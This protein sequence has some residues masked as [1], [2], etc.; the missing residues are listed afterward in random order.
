MAELAP[1]NAASLVP[2]G[3]FAGK[4][5]MPLTRPVIVVGS[6]KNSRVLFK[7]DTVST[8]HSLLIHTDAGW[9]V[10]DLSSRTHTILNGKP[11]RESPL[12]NG[13]TITIGA[14]V[15]HF[16]TVGG[17]AK[18]IP[19]PPAA[20]EITGAEIPVPIDT[21]TML[22]GRRPGCEV[23]LLEESASLIHAVIFESDGVHYLR[24][25]Y[26]RN[27]TYLNDVKT[28]QSP[29]KFGDVIRIGETVLKYV[30][31]RSVDTFDDDISVSPTAALT[32]T[33]EEAASE[34]GSLPAVAD[35][36][37]I[38]DRAVAAA[39]T[40]PVELPDDADAPVVPLGRP[41]RPTSLAE[42]LIAGRTSPL[43]AKAPEPTERAG[44]PVPPVS[45]NAVELLAGAV[46]KDRLIVPAP[47]PDAGDPELDV[48]GIG[49]PVT[50]AYTDLPE[51]VSVPITS[52]TPSLAIEPQHDL[53]DDAPSLATTLAA[54]A[55][56]PT[57]VPSEPALE[58]VTPPVLE[59][60]AVASVP[61]VD[62]THAAEPLIELT[63]ADEL[64]EADE[65]NASAELDA[66]VEPP[67]PPVSKQAKALLAGAV[68]IERLKPPVSALDFA[69]P[70]AIAESSSPAAFDAELDTEAAEADVLG[71]SSPTIE[72]APIEPATSDDDAFD[73]QPIEA[74]A[75][76]VDVPLAF[77][78]E[79]HEA[80][81]ETAGE[82]A[83][84]ASD[85]A[86]DEEPHGIVEDAAAPTPA[87]PVA[88]DPLT[89][90][91]LHP[92]D[93]F[94][95]LVP[96]PPLVAEPID[97]AAAHH[98]VD[99]QHG[100]H[101]EPEAPLAVVTPADMVPASPE[102][103]E[104]AELQAQ[105]RAA[106]SDPSTL[107]DRPLLS[108]DAPL[109][110]AEDPLMSKAARRARM[111]AEMLETNEDYEEEA[112][113]EAQSIEFAT[114]PASAVPP[115][116]PIIEPEPPTIVP[117]DELLPEA[118]TAA[119]VESATPEVVDQEVV[120]VVATD[121]DGAD[122][123]DDEEIAVA[124]EG[125][126]PTL[127]AGAI[128][129]TADASRSIAAATEPSLS[130]VVAAVL[131]PA[132][133]DIATR[134][135]FNPADAVSTAAGVEPGF[136]ELDDD[137]V[138]AATEARQRLEVLDVEPSTTEFSTTES[139]TSVEPSAEPI[140]A[141][142]IVDDTAETLAHPSHTPFSGVPVA[143]ADAEIDAQ[144]DAEEI[145]AAA[146]HLAE[147]D[148]TDISDESLLANTAAQERDHPIVDD[149]VRALVGDDAA[150]DAK[151][152]AFLDRMLD[153]VPDV[154]PT[155]SSRDEVIDDD[156]ATSLVDEDD[157]ATNFV[158]IN[159]KPADEREA[160]GEAT[161]RGAP[162]VVVHPLGSA[163]TLDAFVARFR[164]AVE[165][166]AM[167]SSLDA[168]AAAHTPEPLPIESIP[169]TAALAD[170]ADE[171]PVQMAEERAPIE[172][173]QLNAGD[174][175]ATVPTPFAA[176]EAAAHEWAQIA[177]AETGHAPNAVDSAVR[178]EDGT[179]IDTTEIDRPGNVHAAEL[180]H[181]VGP[182]PE[183]ELVTPLESAD[184]PTGDLAAPAVDA[185]IESP[186]KRRTRKPTKKEL[187]A[188][189]DAAAAEAAEAARALEISAGE[190]S[191]AETP[192]TEVS[193][194]KPAARGRKPRR[195][196]PEERAAADAAAA[197]AAAANAAADAV[198]KAA[199]EAGTV[200][201]DAGS[202]AAA[203]VVERSMT[204]DAEQST[205]PQVDEVPADGPSAELDTEFA[206]G[207]LTDLP[208]ASV[209][210]STASQG[211]TPTVVAVETLGVASI[212]S[213]SAESTSLASV[214]AEGVE[215]VAAVADASE[216]IAL[217]A[218]DAANTD[219][220][221]SLTPTATQHVDGVV[222]MRSEDVDSD[223][224]S[225]SADALAIQEI[226]ATPEADAVE[227]AL[228]AI[229]VFATSEPDTTDQ[230]TD[231]AA[232]RDEI[233]SSPLVDVIPAAVEGSS[234]TVGSLEPLAAASTFGEMS[235][236][237][238][239]GVEMSGIDAT[240]IDPV[241]EP[242]AATFIEAS[243]AAEPVVLDVLLAA[244]QAEVA[245][246]LIAEPATLESTTVTAVAEALATESADADADADAG[247][248]AV[249]TPDLESNVDAPVVQWRMSELS[250]PSELPTA[251][252]PPA[253]LSAQPTQDDWARADEMPP[254][255]SRVGFIPQPAPQPATNVANANA[256]RPPT[257]IVNVDLPSIEELEA[258]FNDA[259]ADALA[260]A[261]GVS[262][263]KPALPPTPFAGA[264]SDAP[265]VEQPG[266]GKW[267]LDESLLDA[268]EPREPAKRLDVPSANGAAAAPKWELDESLLDALENPPAAPM[269]PVARAERPAPPKWELDE[270]LLDQAESV[271]PI[272]GA[273]PAPRPS[274]LPSGMGG[275]G[276]MMSLGG[277]GWNGDGNS[278]EFNPFASDIRSAQAGTGVHGLRGGPNV[279]RRA[280]RRRRP[281]PGDALPSAEQAVEAAP[282][283][284]TP[285]APTVASAVAVLPA[286]AST[287][288]AAAKLEPIRTVVREEA[289][290]VDA[291]VAPV[292]DC[293]DAIADDAS[294]QT[295][296]A[297]QVDSELDDPQAA[298]TAPLDLS[299]LDL[300]ADELPAADVVANAFARSESIAPAELSPL[301]ELA[302]EAVTPGTE[303]TIGQAIEQPIEEASSEA[304]VVAPITPPAPILPPR[305]RRN[306][307]ARG[308]AIV[309]QSFDTDV[310]AHSPFA[311]QALPLVDAFSS[312]PSGDELDEVLARIGASGHGTAG[313]VD[314]HP[315]I[316]QDLP[317]AQP[318]DA[319]AT[320]EDVF[321][322]MPVATPFASHVPIE[323]STAR[324]NGTA[325][326]VRRSR[327]QIN[328]LP[329]LTLLMVGLMCLAGL[330]AYYVPVPVTVHGEIAFE[331]L[332]RINSIDQKTMQSNILA[333]LDNGVARAARNKVDDRF[334]NGFLDRPEAFKAVTDSAH[335]DPERP[336]VLVLDH[337]S[338]LNQSD[339]DRVRMEEL[340]KQF[341]SANQ[342]LIDAKN[343]QLQAIHVLEQTI[344]DCDKQAGELSPQR[345]ALEQTIN[346]AAAKSDLDKVEAEL[347]RLEAARDTATQEIDRRATELK[348]L[349]AEAMSLAEPPPD[350][351]G[352]STADEPFSLE[353]FT[354]GFARAIARAEFVILADADDSG[355][356]ALPLPAMPTT[357]PASV[358]A[359]VPA[360][361]AGA[362]ATQPTTQPALSLADAQAKIDALVAQRTTA[363]G[364][365]DRL[366]AAQSPESRKARENFDSSLEA[367]AGD[368]EQARKSLG[369]R[370]D[371]LRYIE[372]ARKLQDQIRAMTDTLVRR[373]QQQ[374]TRMGEF[375]RRLDELTDATREQR[376]ASDEQ[377]Q[378]HLSNLAIEQRRLNA[379]RE[380]NVD[381]VE[382][383]E[384]ER[385]VELLK[386]MIAGRQEIL[387]DPK[388]STV[389]HELEAMIQTTQRDMDADRVQNEKLL[390]DVQETFRGQQPAVEQLPDDQKRLAETLAAR[391]AQIDLARQ[392]YTAALSIAAGGDEQ[393]ISEAREQIASLDATIASQR[394]AVD[395]MQRRQQDEQQQRNAVAAAQAAVMEHRARVASL[396]D[397]A[398]TALGSAKT[399]R[400]DIDAKYADATRKRAAVAASYEAGRRA[401][402]TH[403]SIVQQL[404]DFNAKRSQANATLTEQQRALNFVVVPVLPP[405]TR[406]LEAARSDPRIAYGAA[407]IFG[408]MMLFAPL[409]YREGRS[410][411]LS[412]SLAHSA[413]HADRTPEGLPSGARTA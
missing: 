65:R 277:V 353:N 250:P 386:S 323:V 240:T 407:G 318:R 41:S 316:T 284:S 246:T 348:R 96:S 56:R 102:A 97:V 313:Q 305:P 183:G 31:D 184:A 334:G 147:A 116:P 88:V 328:K 400:D 314:D 339:G 349:E 156:S 390:A 47:M 280:S 371:V 294:A 324:S 212:D 95:P 397:M 205:E 350:P 406:V 108:P 234:V 215:T 244:G 373:Q 131:S 46:P 235:G 107:V 154:E 399:A 5:A 172:V 181:A 66:P 71:L 322:G 18:P 2:V 133:V 249:A 291:V 62:E 150:I 125:E 82:T 91:E 63:Q 378:S 15:F 372:A 130:E 34:A 105:I 146:E 346:D 70:E 164:D 36:V 356:V 4:P 218:G 117:A 193:A 330:G 42:S 87:E 396:V 6:G 270:S 256:P 159:D 242:I 8:T 173:D 298:E 39:Q 61:V 295:A 239:P 69:E 236:V 57:V 120:D 100:D 224:S 198:A 174:V 86:A 370:P 385:H 259:F 187:K 37:E 168:I 142:T 362:P 145:D 32:G 44:P 12:K 405:S 84:E 35:D 351:K 113:R 361:T 344:A 401:T 264:K 114:V 45:P 203:D 55:P 252:I 204:P 43:Q 101:H 94:T 192:A 347:K 134:D 338:N 319:A 272:T 286:A 273:M 365:L 395:S 208:I 169:G 176:A 332:E 10:R 25:L 217:D 209:D 119:A 136:G 188:A 200:A 179:P 20:F 364:T 388:A 343:K 271:N 74:S 296:D 52:L 103:V 366:L 14:F 306:R 230:A 287:V 85:Y 274:S 276:G 368:V 393:Q 292:D 355:G 261:E 60:P 384:L 129:T 106:L 227:P 331:N 289:D 340:L 78:P 48:L 392:R 54:M 262:F 80:A 196:S 263:A 40:L 128:A 189:A 374:I 93:V 38:D 81:D 21:R 245:Q 293:L 126:S 79:V 165:A 111:I 275:G 285:V 59:L 3:A 260:M 300:D 185:P 50:A 83:D 207:D 160:L 58:V 171:A 221:G 157:D 312:P 77:E 139:S 98:D 297:P 336:N 138:A 231:Q 75:D 237:E 307:P 29:L 387:N 202:L 67:V 303:P 118:A 315:P 132:V 375:K 197:E 269:A 177:A 27:G 213:G 232:S 13:D 158:A 369:D 180:G 341:A 11:T 162:Q 51:V 23:R 321:G 182:L 191:A 288:D 124:A 144:I 278:D 301:D 110:A 325:P 22:V 140:P 391:L 186:R 194:A 255:R 153:R 283:E 72:P 383:A 311:A 19:V 206:A 33:A 220:A 149:S 152:D 335:F 248:G 308:E 1:K 148:R 141:E 253:E 49:P 143:S 199:T 127:P 190:T 238:M 17:S 109:V 228:G 389:T 7:S 413:S 16:V 398:R 26:S 358:M 223:L 241:A 247:A 219:E 410:R 359:I 53:D 360:I 333:K 167:P 267:E 210:E 382:L 216:P 342:D 317:I 99:D 302:D 326:G 379:A 352:L 9:Y 214:D 123:V 251:T 151:L 412:Q 135:A 299:A 161:D 320:M 222:A 329:I 309:D 304:P 195:L 394:D 345:S 122:E 137:E 155:L 64:T 170:E 409:I 243:S 175:I 279:P 211:E 233:D 282:I 73:L 404:A 229:D 92:S 403:D 354:S 290:A 402:A 166:E 254:P 411:P 115:V 68:P 225:V 90:S 30:A 226:A 28:H 257:A 281:I 121:D 266:A 310:A 376:Y 178:L 265:T 363:K 112:E 380:S 357:A 327:Q 104:L 201:F 408:V 76:E 258:S 377:L 163:A 268:L 367:F 89:P 24:D 337:H 381:A